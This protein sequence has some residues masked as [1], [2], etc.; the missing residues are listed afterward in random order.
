MKRTV[1]ATIATAALLLVT[2]AAGAGDV[3]QNTVFNAG[4]LDYLQNGYAPPA[5]RAEKAPAA[6]KNTIKNP[7]LGGMTVE[8]IRNG[9]KAPATVAEAAPARKT[10]RIKN[11]MFTDN[12]IDY[13][14]KNDVAVNLKALFSSSS[15]AAG[16]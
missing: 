7:M 4:D 8:D 9:Y 11:T 5:P 13:C 12:V 3:Y 14:E 1:I 16:E 2:A 10:G 6:K 15:V